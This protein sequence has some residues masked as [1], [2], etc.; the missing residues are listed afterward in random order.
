M[1]NFFFRKPILPPEGYIMKD[2]I[3]KCPELDACINAS[4]WCDG[5]V[6]CPSGYDESLG[7]CYI[8]FQLPPL[9]LAFGIIGIICLATAV[10]VAMLRS[11]IKRKERRKNHLNVLPSESSLFEEK[12]VI[13]WHS[14]GSVR[15]VE[16]D[17]VTTVWYFVIHYNLFI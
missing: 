5:V 7:H 14:D 15:Y 6:H 10:T 1:L 11:C 13:C 2:C 12:E 17:R 9:Y 4:L 16:V 8:I 3:H